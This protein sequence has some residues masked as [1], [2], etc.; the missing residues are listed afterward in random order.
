LLA[1]TVTPDACGKNSSIEAMAAVAASASTAKT[2]ASRVII[3]AM[4]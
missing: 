2:T 4:R 3:S 1:A